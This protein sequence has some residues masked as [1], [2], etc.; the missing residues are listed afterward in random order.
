M[1]A[2]TRRPIRGAL[3][4]LKGAI[5]VLEGAPVKVKAVSLRTDNLTVTLLEK[6]G[7]YEMGSE[8]HVHTY[9]YTEVPPS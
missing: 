2:N 5:P 4:W 1:T 9:E 6:R 7:A 8:I 3:G